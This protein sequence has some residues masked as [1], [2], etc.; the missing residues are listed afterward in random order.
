MPLGVA[1]DAS[2]AIDAL[3]SLTKEQS[4]AA[5]VTDN[6]QFRR[7]IRRTQSY[8]N[9]PYSEIL[10]NT[11]GNELM[12]IDMLRAK[13]SFFGATSFDPRSDRWVRINMYKGAP[14]P[15]TL[16]EANADDWVYPMMEVDAGV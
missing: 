14:Y 4:T 10:D 12:P 5:F 7:I 6:P 15:E 3:K 2:L 16:T 13:L 11:L 9:Q 8:A 1:R